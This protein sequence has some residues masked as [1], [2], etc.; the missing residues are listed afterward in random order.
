MSDSL[1]TVDLTN[2]E[3]GDSTVLHILELMK[4][5][6]KVK[7]L[8]LIRN[9]LTDDGVAK[10]LPYFSNLISLNLSQNQLTD[11]ILSIIIDNRPNLPLLRSLVLSQTKI[12]ERRSKGLMERLKKMEMAI[13]VWY[14]NP[15]MQYI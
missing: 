14:L 12:V 11:H 8:K 13:S 10:M 5:N 1:E 4:E 6:T 9:K 7:S 15:I 3:L 2:A